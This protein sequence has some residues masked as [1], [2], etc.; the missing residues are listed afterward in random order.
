MSNESKATMLNIMEKNQT[1]TK[2]IKSLKRNMK[3]NQQGCVKYWN[4]RGK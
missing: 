1:L 2:Q 3:H 4:K